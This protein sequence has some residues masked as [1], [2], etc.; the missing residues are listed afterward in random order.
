[1]EPRL[2]L[3]E[4]LARQGIHRVLA[5]L[6]EDIKDEAN[7]CAILL[8]THDVDEGLL[9][10]FEGNAVGDGEPMSAEELPRITLFLDTIWDE[11]DGDPRLFREEVVTT[12]LHE[13]GHF[14]GLDEDEVE[15]LGLG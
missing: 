3:K 14:L 13:L 9:G 10:L 2:P 11:A 1:M 8:A 6:P 4:R 15:A 7:R 5:S 12:L